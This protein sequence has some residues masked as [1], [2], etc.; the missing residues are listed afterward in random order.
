MLITCVNRISFHSL[1]QMFSHLLVFVSAT[2]GPWSGQFRALDGGSVIG[3]REP[4]RHDV[5]ATWRDVSVSELAPSGRHLPPF[6]RTVKRSNTGKQCI[7]IVHCAYI[8]RVGPS[9]HWSPCEFGCI[10]FK[11]HRACSCYG[12]PQDP[13]NFSCDA[14]WMF[15]KLFL[16]SQ[17][18][19]R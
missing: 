2:A 8:L 19:M 16:D 12:T 7:D 14:G 11:T 18:N 15:V 9:H 4:P 17:S 13:V 10:A 5:T 3:F 6:H 1:H